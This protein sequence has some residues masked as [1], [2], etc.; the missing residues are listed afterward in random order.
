MTNIYICTA[1]LLPLLS[2]VEFNGNI[3]DRFPNVPVPK[4]SFGIYFIFIT[5]TLVIKIRIHS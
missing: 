5:D 3:R 1:S 2:V 4:V